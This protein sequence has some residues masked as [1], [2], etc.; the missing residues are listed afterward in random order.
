M[1]L[2][3]GL[4]HRVQLVA[5]GEPLDRRDLVAVGLDREHVHDFTLRPSRWTVHAPQLL[6][7]QPTTVPVLPSFS[8]RYWTSN[9][10][11]FDVV[12]DLCSVDREV[13]ARHGRLLLDAWMD[14][15]IRSR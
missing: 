9:S 12:G 6:V 15:V 14:R 5:V 3:E 11:G 2:A 13:D 4:L 10:A 8:R 1:T 7:S